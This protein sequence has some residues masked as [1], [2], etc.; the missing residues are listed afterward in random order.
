MGIRLALVGT[1]RTW[2]GYKY[3]HQQRGLF[4]FIAYFFEIAD[5]VCNSTPYDYLH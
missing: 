3:Q 2:N 1:I 4:D 5:Q